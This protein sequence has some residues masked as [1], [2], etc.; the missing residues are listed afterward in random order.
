MHQTPLAYS[1]SD[2]RDLFTYQWGEMR[3]KL[4]R[5]NPEKEY[6][7]LLES[8][9][10][11]LTGR[12]FRKLKD[13]AFKKDLKA[14]SNIIKLPTKLYIRLMNLYDVSPYVRNKLNFKLKEHENLI[15]S[16]HLGGG[17]GG[18]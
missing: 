9:F 5:K 12:T 14:H 1:K 17:G 8:I 13:E 10:L 2:T 16:L 7:L 4:S 6:D 15:S 11:L 3:R 18:L